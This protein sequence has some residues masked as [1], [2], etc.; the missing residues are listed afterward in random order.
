[1]P[2]NQPNQSG[3]SGQPAEKKKLKGGK[4][5]FYKVEGDKTSTDKKNCPRCERGVFLAS[6]KNRFACGRCGYTEFLDGQGQRSQ[7]RQEPRP[8]QPNSQSK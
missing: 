8:P 5:Q 2:E 6:H 7:P 1:M 4:W 3:Q